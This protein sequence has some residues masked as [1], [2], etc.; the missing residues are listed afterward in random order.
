MIITIDSENKDMSWVIGKN[1]HSQ[2][3]FAKK[4]RKGFGIGWFVNERS[5]RVAFLDAADEISY[6]RYSSDTFAYLHNAELVSPLAGIGILT[7]FFGTIYPEKDIVTKQTA[8]ILALELSERTLKMMSYFTS[9]RIETDNI[10]SWDGYKTVRVTAR[11]TLD[12][13]VKFLGI[14]FLQSMF[15]NKARMPY[16]SDDLAK[17]YIDALI[18][19]DAPFPVRY[20]FKKN[21]LGNP[22]LFSSNKEL[23]DTGGFNFMHG[24]T[25][26]ARIAWVK[27]QIGAKNLIDLGCGEGDYFFLENM[28][29]TYH[30]VDIDSDVLAYAKRRLAR[31]NPKSEIK[32][33]DDITHVK[34]NARVDILL[35]EVIE[36]IDLEILP[37]F[38]NYLLDSFNVNKIIITTPNKA[39]NPYWGIPDGEF[40]RDDH[41]W[42]M[43]S[44]EL[45]DFMAG[46]GYN[47]EIYPVGD[48]AGEIST[49]TGIIIYSEE[50]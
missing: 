26:D 23:L 44:Q 50:I 21:L 40:R 37:D 42:E 34:T 20:A 10:W 35:A 45:S 11:T 18:D 16:R 2:I 22:T 3:P 25:Q 17:K 15:D 8:T 1:P 6:P 36:H 12:S 9:F 33:Y 30:A 7:K 43:T 39:F 4:I 24:S 47:F 5:Y 14:F 27:N 13:F 31:K 49:T 28:F 32:F 41:K 19:L 38:I 46:L 29:D 48:M